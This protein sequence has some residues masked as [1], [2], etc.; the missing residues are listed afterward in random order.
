MRYLYKVTL[1]PE[2]VGG[3]TVECA[4]LEGVV[5]YGASVVEA[6]T[7]AA[8]ALRTYVTALLED[9]RDV[10]AAT[11]YPTQ[12][13]TKSIWVSFSVDVES[14]LGRCVLAAEAARM[15]NVGRSRVSQL[16]S[17]GRLKAIRVG[18]R[19]FVEVASI[20][21]RLALRGGKGRPRGR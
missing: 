8:D 7:Q 3:Y 13:G 20:E 12:E 17:Q 21:E 9:G 6:A 16:V 5:T 19:V 11:D 2:V 15:L 1:T 18:G 10:P 14:L 4:D